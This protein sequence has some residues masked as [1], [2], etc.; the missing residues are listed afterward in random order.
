[1]PSSRPRE[2]EIILELETLSCQGGMETEAIQVL[3]GRRAKALKVPTY[4]RMWVKRDVGPG[5]QRKGPS[6]S[7]G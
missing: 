2:R 5:W 4:P 1:M 6:L 7:S 3:W